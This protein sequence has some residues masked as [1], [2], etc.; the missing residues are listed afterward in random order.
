MCYF[1]LRASAL[2]DRTYLVSVAELT[3]KIVVVQ[4]T[5]YILYKDLALTLQCV[6][7]LCSLQWTQGPLIARLDAIR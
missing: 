6:M 4:E 2:Y 3:Q 5:Y 1:Q 7:L